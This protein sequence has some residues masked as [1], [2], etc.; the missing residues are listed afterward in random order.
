MFTVFF[1]TYNF[2]RKKYLRQPSID[3]DFCNLSSSGD[4]V[5]KERA[6]DIDILCAFKGKLQ[7]VEHITKRARCWEESDTLFIQLT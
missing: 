5:Y 7:S 1:L 2:F 3:F 6:G 4:V